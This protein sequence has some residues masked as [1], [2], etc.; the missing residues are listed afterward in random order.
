MTPNSRNLVL[1]KSQAACL[2]ALRD[3]KHAKTEIAI[4][5]KLDLIKTATELG[6]LAQLG[7]ARQ[8]QSKRWHTTGRGKACRFETVPDRVRRNSG[9]PGPGARRVLQLL[10]RPMAGSEIAE[11]L[12]V[13]RQRAHQL[14]IKLHAQGRVRFGDP[15]SP[16]WIVMRADD[17]TPLLSRDEARVLSAI[18]REYAT[19][20]TK[21]GIPVRMP[22]NKLQ[23]ILDRLMVGRFV[24]AAEGWQGNRLYRI[25]G[26][27]LKHSQR[28]Q[29]AR[30]AKAPR[31]PVESDRVAKVLSAILDSGPLRI[32]EVT[33]ALEISH[34]SIN[35]LMQYLKRKHLV[36][37]T[38]QE[39]HAP[40]SLTEEGHAALAEM[41]R[42]HALSS[43]PL[44]QV[45][46]PLRVLDIRPNDEF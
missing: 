5:A 39:L 15:K 29:S 18:P 31:L 22:E 34:Q 27:G 37:K 24:G 23:Q 45:D 41:T 9:L 21:I 44:L 19:S 35:A 6:A 33:E 26:A 13:S 14:V 28:D 40:Y 42:R 17:K 10:D 11:K 43:M 3:R 30:H 25:T 46:L 16:F 32:K 4:Q 7:L 2:I 38:G 1:T 20:A 36:K 8:D 12:G